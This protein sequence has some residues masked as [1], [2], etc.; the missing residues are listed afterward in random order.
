VLKGAVLASDIDGSAGAIG[1]IKVECTIGVV[2]AVTFDAAWWEAVIFVIAGI[3]RVGTTWTIGGDGKGGVWDTGSEGCCIP[4]GSGS[5]AKAVGVYAIGI[6]VDGTVRIDGFSGAKGNT[7]QLAKL[8]AKT[9]STNGIAG[10]FKGAVLASDIDGSAGA[11]GHIKIKCSIGVVHAVTFDA[12][13]WQAVIFVIAGIH[14]VG[15]AGAIRGHRKGGV[16]NAGSEGCCITNRP[17][18]LAKAIGVYAIGIFVDGT[19]RING[20]GGANGNTS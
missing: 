13:G 2:H 9:L 14:R 16:W 11:I 19:V 8:G 20:F 3:H 1:H 5:L 7:S 10:V 17:S 12:T 15:T 18:S 6:F 4:N